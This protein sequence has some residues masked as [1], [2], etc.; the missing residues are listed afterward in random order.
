VLLADVGPKPFDFSTTPA[1]ENKVNMITG[2]KFYMDFFNV[3]LEPKFLVRPHGQKKKLPFFI[4]SII[5]A[6]RRRRKLKNNEKNM[7]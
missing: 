6:S 4:R 5:L 3:Q 1:G 2:A 7:L